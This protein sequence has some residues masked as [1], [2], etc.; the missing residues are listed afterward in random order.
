MFRDRPRRTLH[1]ANVGHGSGPQPLRLGRCVDTDEDDIGF[2]DGLDNIGGE[3]EVR[4]PS[5][6]LDRANK[7]GQGH[8]GIERAVPGDAHYLQQTILVDGEVG[9]IPRRHALLVQVDDVD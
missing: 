2:C 6:E 3:D 8:G 4:L 7:A 5:L 1:G 9:R